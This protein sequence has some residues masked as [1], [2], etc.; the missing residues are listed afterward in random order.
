M[1]AVYAARQWK[2]IAYNGSCSNPMDAARPATSPQRAKAFGRGAAACRPESPA[3]CGSRSR[4]AAMDGCGQH[5]AVIRVR[6][7][8]CGGDHHVSRCDGIGEMTVH[9][10]AGPIQYC[11]VYIWTAGQKSASPFGMDVG[12]PERGKEIAVGRTRQQIAKTD[13]IDYV[14]IQ[15]RSPAG[16]RLLQAKFLVARSQPVER[17]VAAELGLAAPDEN[18]LGP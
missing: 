14:G 5:V 2:A 9:D 8:E 12:V 11:G 16:H 3:D 15:Q 6:Q 10:F 1:E 4:R 7:I 13:R 18:V 17:L